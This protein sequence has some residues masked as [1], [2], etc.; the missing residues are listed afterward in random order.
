M[1]SWSKCFL[2][3]SCRRIAKAMESGGGWNANYQIEITLQID[4]ACLS[5]E[6]FILSWLLC[7]SIIKSQSRYCNMLTR[8]GVLH[9]TWHRYLWQVVDFSQTMRNQLQQH[10]MIDFGKH[11]NTV[12]ELPSTKI[13]IE[14]N[15][16]ALSIYKKTQK[17]IEMW[18]W[19]GRVN[20]VL[21]EIVWNV[22]DSISFLIKFL[23]ALE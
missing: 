15:R 11:F 13:I 4:N 8:G 18:I 12:S 3:K 1:L 6:P 10:P 22:I 20:Q 5:V 23:I 2:D 14:D 7:V 9:L 17:Y 16:T 19:S 21:L